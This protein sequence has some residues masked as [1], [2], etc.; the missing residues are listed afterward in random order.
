MLRSLYLRRRSP[1]GCFQIGCGRYGEEK[2][3]TLV[4]NNTSLIEVTWTMTITVTYISKQGNCHTNSKVTTEKLNT[5]YSTE[6]KGKKLQETC[7]NQLTESIEH[8]YF[9]NNP[10]PT[11]PKVTGI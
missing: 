5:M 9:R 6:P 3:C 11:P 10:H 2:V 7:E 8:S 1:L 4:G